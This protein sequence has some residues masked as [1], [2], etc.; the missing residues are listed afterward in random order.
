MLLN[1]ALISKVKSKK[2]KIDSLINSDSPGFFSNLV[3]DRYVKNDEIPKITVNGILTESDAQSFFKETD[4]WNTYNVS[5][6]YD[7]S[8][9]KVRNNIEVFK[10]AM[11]FPFDFVL[12]FA[13][14][15]LVVEIFGKYKSDL[16]VKNHRE[17]LV[18]RDA[19]YYSK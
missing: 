19:G 16:M 8:N 7:Y 15:F 1:Q 9:P 4:Y 13:K 12:H 2:S 11:P 10:S 5:R 3:V 17:F 14:D 18:L 6:F